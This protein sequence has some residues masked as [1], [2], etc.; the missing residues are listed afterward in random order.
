M[1]SADFFLLFGGSTN[2]GRTFLAEENRP[3]AGEVV[4][5][6][7]DFWRRRFGADPRVV[8]TPVSVDGVSR[9]VVGV[10]E[11]EFD[12]RVFGLVPDVFLPLRIAPDS[13]SHAAI[14][15]VAGRLPATTMPAANNASL[16]TLTAEFRRRFRA[17]WP[18]KSPSGR[19]RCRRYCFAAIVPRFCR[20]QA[21]SGLLLIACANVTNL[22][23]VRGIRRRREMART[24]L[25][26][27]RARLLRQL[28]VECLL[29]SAAGGRPSWPPAPQPSCR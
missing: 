15:G 21:P 9:L 26:D 14:L 20:S 16:V 10:V 8:G 19:H 11:R 13:T 2:H 7:H 25:G 29:L 4:V 6:G 28:S 24:A 12:V 23:V 18:R 27:T 5:L 22:L 17:C 3:G 1:V